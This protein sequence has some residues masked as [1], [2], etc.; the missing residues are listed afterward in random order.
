MT[1]N[2]DQNGALQYQEDTTCEV[3]VASVVTEKG[4][5]A[6][7]CR[8]TQSKQEAPGRAAPSDGLKAASIKTVESISAEDEFT[9]AQLEDM[10]AKCRLRNEQKEL[11]NVYANT[12]TIT[13]ESKESSQVVGPTLFLDLEIEGVPMEAVVDCGSPATIIF[14]SMLHEI[15]RS[16]RRAGN[17]PPQISK[18][19]IKV[20]GKDRKKSGHELVCTAQ[21]EVTIQADGQSACVPMIVQPNSEQAYLLGTNATSL[22]GLRFLRANNKPLRAGTEPKQSLTHVRLVRT[23]SVLSQASKIVKA[24]IESIDRK[25]EHCVF[26]PDVDVM[27]SSGL[28]IP[29]TVLTIGEKGRVYIPLQSKLH[30]G[31]ELCVIEPFVATTL[32][33]VTRMCEKSQKVKSSCFKVTV[34]WRRKMFQYGGAL[35]TITRL[36]RAKFL[37]TPIFDQ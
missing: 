17:P 4:H 1:Q 13:I 7:N 20:Y 34:Q 11:G 8:N 29:D 10:L 14:R 21:L 15:A 9:E 3:T 27:E 37:S 6:S 26:E 2:R 25:G 23:I 31:A 12:C 19:S 24:E 35:D 33:D 22:L 32:D 36:A 30:R 18:P 5:L 28:I 16:L